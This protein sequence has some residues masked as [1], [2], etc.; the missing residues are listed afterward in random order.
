MNI[1]ETSMN[2]RNRI[3]YS[4]YFYNGFIRPDLLFKQ[5]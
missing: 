2:I 4:I 1:Q 5:Q 3:I